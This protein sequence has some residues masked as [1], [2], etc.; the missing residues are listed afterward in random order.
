MKRIA[1]KLRRRV[2][3]RAAVPRAAFLL[4]LAAVFQIAGVVLPA[5]AA[6]TVDD[7]LPGSSPHK[8]INRQ[9]GVF[10]RMI[11]DQLIDSDHALVERG[12]NT[13][14]A[15]VPGQG[16]VFAFEFSLVG[17]PRGRGMHLAAL[18]H[19]AELDDLGVILD[20]DGDLL[21]LHDKDLDEKEIED[22]KAKG[23]DREKQVDEVRRKL[24]AERAQG[25]VRVKEELVGVLAEYGDMLDAIPGN[26]WVTLV[27]RP[28]DGPWGEKKITTLVLRARLADVKERVEGR[29]DDAAFRKRIVVEEYGG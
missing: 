1:Q 6:S 22:L 20:E 14:G 10:A 5:A 4:A 3:F 18:G 8:K 2:P 29:V 13:V 15:Y 28:G 19:L 16:A 23:K 9:V 27:A 7:P 26:E 12:R 11:D 17:S 21:Y 25:Y 24:E